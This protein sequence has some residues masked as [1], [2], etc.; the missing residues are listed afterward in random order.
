M[1]LEPAADPDA[2]YQLLVEAHDDLTAEQGRLVDTRLILLLANHIGDPAVIAQAV[3]AARDGLAAA[4]SGLGLCSGSAARTVLPLICRT[5]SPS[6]EPPELDV[7]A[8]LGQDPVVD[9]QLVA[10]VLQHDEA[11]DV[12][13]PARRCSPS[14]PGGPHRI[15]SSRSRNGLSASTST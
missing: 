6:T 8:V 5:S 1:R 14:A 12:H 3:A 2:I 11:V 10:A 4:R 9:L 13:V 15:F 7:E